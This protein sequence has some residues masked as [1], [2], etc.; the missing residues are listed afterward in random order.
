MFSKM[1]NTMIRHKESEGKRQVT[2]RLSMEFPVYSFQFP[3]L[4]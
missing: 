2:T 4:I 3:V 1:F